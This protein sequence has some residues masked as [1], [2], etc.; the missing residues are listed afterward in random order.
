[1]AEQE[2]F[3]SPN[4]NRLLSIA[5][6]AKYLAWIVLVVYILNAILQIFQYQFFLNNN[7]QPQL[8]MWLFLKTNP[9]EGF[10]LGIDILTTIVRGIVY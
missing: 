5:T 3:F 7:V 1:M 10:R 6:W 8:D 9:F 4:H 2:E